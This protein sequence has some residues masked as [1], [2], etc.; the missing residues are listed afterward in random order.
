MN[1]KLKSKDKRLNIRCTQELLDMVD[2]LRSAFGMNRT[3]VI[4]YLVQY[5][6]AL[7]AKQKGT[8][9]DR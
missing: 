3:E 7:A 4:E 6:P 1:R 9:D 2:E 5:I 8:V